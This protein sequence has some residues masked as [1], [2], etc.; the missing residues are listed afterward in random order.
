MDFTSLAN[1]T[2]WNWGRIIAV[3]AIYVLTVLTSLALVTVVLVRL[4][5]DYLRRPVAAPVA[6]HAGWCSRIGWLGRNLLGVLLVVLGVLLCL[7][8]VPGQG[9]LTIVVGI[10]FLD[11]PGKH[12]LERKVAS[13]P[14]VLQSINRLRLRFG[15]PPLSFDSSPSK[16]TDEA[17]RG[18][19]DEAGPGGVP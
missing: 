17:H 8:G 18:R 14:K 1:L 13:H 4:P 3:A 10:L 11:F 19:I 7:P 6:D 16:A 12:R 2:D 15:R 9:I 5:A